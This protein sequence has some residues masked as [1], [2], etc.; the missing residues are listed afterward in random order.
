M[1]SFDRLVAL[2]TRLRGPDGCPWDREQTL[3]TLKTYLVEE[4]Y[5]VLD[6]LDSGDPVAHQEELGDLMLQVVFQAQMRAEENTFTIDD[7]NRGIHDKL[8]RRHPHVFGSVKA[9]T[10]DEVLDQWEKIKAREKQGTSRPSLLDHVPAHL[11]ALL[12]ALRLTEKAARV[13]F[14]WAAED[15]L[16]AKVQEEWTE[17]QEVA[18]DGGDPA[19]FAEELG[20]LLF[21]LA[22]LARRRGLDPEETLRQANRKFENRFG[23]IEARLKE[24]ERTLEDASLEEMDRLWNEAKT[25]ERRTATDPADR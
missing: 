1:E 4:T 15:D 16:M 25:I 19:R 11:P 3:E 7:V 18:A 5:E 8:V 22:N 12:R 17:L 20:D 21:V 13:G 6:A 23:H 14:D 24:S 10:A 2:M 9:S